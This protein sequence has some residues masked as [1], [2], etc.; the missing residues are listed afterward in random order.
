[1]LELSADPPFCQPLFIDAHGTRFCDNVI[2]RAGEAS[3]LPGERVRIPVYL[4]GLHCP[5]LASVTEVH[6]SLRFNASLLFP[7]SSFADRREGSDRVME[8]VLPAVVDDNQVLATL[9]FTAMLGDAEATPLILENTHFVNATVPILEVPGRFTLLGVCRDGGTRLF[10]DSGRISLAQNRP[11]PF[12]PL[13]VI[14]Y[15]TIETAHIL[16]LVYDITGREVAR[17]VDGIQDAG[18]HTV[19]FDATALPS[20]QYRY[21]L[22]TPQEVRMRSMVF[23]K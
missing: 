8:L 3:A 1:M 5:M 19:S 18:R 10:S 2:I 7:Q 15:E 17:L 14:D 21:A 9:E 13:T 12:N 22:I 4:N 6:A 20:G 23:I 16:L 11:N